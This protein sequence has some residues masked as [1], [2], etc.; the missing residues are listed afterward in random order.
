MII[1]NFFGK[2]ANVDVLYFLTKNR[3][4]KN[5]LV[6]FRRSKIELPIFQILTGSIGSFVNFQNSVKIYRLDRGNFREP[7]HSY[8]CSNMFLL[9]RQKLFCFLLVSKTGICVIFKC[10]L[11]TLIIHQIQIARIRKTNRFLMFWYFFSSSCKQTP[12]CCL[13]GDKEAFFQNPIHLPALMHIA[14]CT[15]I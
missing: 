1:V 15:S 5:Y 13:S 11:S 12:L 10:R 7:N 3:N 2:R 4:I 8:L 6:I 9:C 14:Q